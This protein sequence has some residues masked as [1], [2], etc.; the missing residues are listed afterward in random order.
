[1]LH[2]TTSYRSC[3]VE[4]FLTTPFNS[5]YDEHMK[6]LLRFYSVLLVAFAALSSAGAAQARELC[7][8]AFA[9][10]CK[11]KIDE[12]A[13]GII[14]TIM[15][16][17]FIIAIVTCLFFMIFGGIRY[18]TAAGDQG[19]TQQARSHIIAALVGLIIALCAFFIVN[20]VSHLFGG[21]GLMNLEILKL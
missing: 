5:S 12:Q 11:I 19:K 15:V 18:I 6:W 14:G 7:P 3:Q 16:V 20:I 4:W 17:L 8:A 2:I 1:M 10:L 9:S 21:V 13:G